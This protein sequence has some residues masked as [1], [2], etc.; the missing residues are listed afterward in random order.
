MIKPLVESHEIESFFNNENSF[1]SATAPKH[2]RKSSIEK[3]SARDFLCRM[4]TLP[5]SGAA[6]KGDDVGTSASATPRSSTPFPARCFFGCKIFF[7]IE[8]SVMLNDRTKRGSRPSEHGGD[9]CCKNRSPP[10]AS[11]S[12]GWE[13]FS[14]AGSP[15]SARTADANHCQ[16]PRSSG[17]CQIHLFRCFLKNLSPYA[18]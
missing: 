18:R 3:T 12:A 7:I 11:H 15:R 5:P 16:S 14:S 8:A 9:A 1:V 13:I 2:V 17:P 6:V 4:G 10:P